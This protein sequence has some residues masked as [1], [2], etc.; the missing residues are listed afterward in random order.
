LKA[1]KFTLEVGMAMPKKAG[2][3]KSLIHMSIRVNLA[4]IRKMEL[5]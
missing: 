5:A 4:A 3:C 2:A 1:E